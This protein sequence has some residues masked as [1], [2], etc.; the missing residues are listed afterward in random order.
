MHPALRHNQ[1]E[2]PPDVGRRGLLRQIKGFGVSAA[3]YDFPKGPGQVH[4]GRSHQAEPQEHHQRPTLR[5]AG[6]R[7]QILDRRCDRHH[8]SAFT[9]HSTIA[10]LFWRRVKVEDFS[11]GKGLKHSMRRSR[12]TLSRTKRQPRKSAPCLSLLRR[13]L[14]NTLKIYLQ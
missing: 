8:H 3:R 6:P 2:A 13:V 1:R 10:Q 14:T 12:A 7:H 4:F 11:L 5:Q 9:R